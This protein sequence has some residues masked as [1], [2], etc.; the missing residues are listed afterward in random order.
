MGCTPSMHTSKTGVIYCQDSEESPSSYTVKDSNHQFA[1]LAGH[2]RTDVTSDPAPYA[3]TPMPMLMPMPP[4]R[5]ESATGLKLDPK[6]VP[7]QRNFI[8]VEKVEVTFLSINLSGLIKT[9]V[10]TVRHRSGLFNVVHN[11]LLVMLRSSGLRLVTFYPFFDVHALENNNVKIGSF[12]MTYESLKVLFVFPKEDAQSEAFWWAA[13]KMQYKTDMVSNHESALACYQER[14]H[15]IVIVDGRNSKPIEAEVF[16]RQDFYSIFFYFYRCVLSLRAVNGSSNTVSAIIVKRSACLDEDLTV[17]PFLNAVQVGHLSTGRENGAVLFDRCRKL[18]PNFSFQWFVECPSRGVCLSELIQLETNDFR[19][20]LRLQATQTMLAAL[21]HCRDVIEVTSAKGEMQVDYA[22]TLVH[23]ALFCSISNICYFVAQYINKTGEQLFGYNCSEISGKN[24]HDIHKIDNVRTQFNDAIEVQLK[25]GKEWEGLYMSRRKSGDAISTQAKI[26]PVTTRSNKVTHHVYIKDCS[27][28]TAF[29]DLPNGKENINIDV[30]KGGVKPT[31]KTSY[32]IKSLTEGIDY[33]KPF[34]FRCIMTTL[35]NRRQSMARIAAM[36]IEA[37]ITKVINFIAAAQENCPVYVAQ[38]LDKALDILRSTELYSPQWLSQQ[39]KSD[40]PITID[41]LGGLLSQGPKIPLNVRRQSEVSF[42]KSQSLQ[43][44]LSL[45]SL[46]I[47]PSNIKSLLENESKWSFNVL[48]LEAITNKRPLVWLGM[49]IF[50]R[51]RVASVLNTDETT[52]QNWLTLI[53]ANYHAQNPY[54]NSTHAA[55]VLQAAACFLDR[56]HIK[57]IFDPLDEAA[58]LLAAAIHDTDHPGKNSAFLCNSNNELA[59]LYNDLSVL[60]SHHS[61]LAFKLTHTDKRVNIFANMDKDDY[62]TIRHSI[63]D[64]V[65]AT[66]MTKHFEHL[67]KFVNSFTKPINEESEFNFEIGQETAD[68][69]T[70]VK[71]VLIK[72]ADVSNPARGLE[73]CIE[74]AHR[75]ATEYFQQTEEEK[76]K[77]LPIVMPMFDRTTCSIPKSQIGFM[78]YFVNDMFESWDV[79][80]DLPELMENLHKNYQYW[81]EQ[82]TRQS[83]TENEPALEPTSI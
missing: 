36:S 2:Y 68:N 63:I 8:S 27:S 9:L 77:G 74:W 73:L 80:A 64:M 19:N 35:M 3:E 52:L 61:A 62:R 5:S 11:E 83:L 56:D 17:I 21:A 39:T 55:D 75:I 10:L 58:C 24:I 46:S 12:A 26:L 51:F 60:E 38:T 50:G 33:Q 71:R 59:I 42:S 43:P 25:N 69:I 82:E 76:A 30:L 4:S 37:P 81:K 78:D 67:A 44:S 79:F 57:Q 14:Y 45:P 7:P 41:L 22:T 53:E 13:K 49:A 47:I 18:G 15:D 31:R 66:E 23:F 40:D 72:C 6:W 34:C 29:G 20:N 1:G 48:Q 65:L 32:D 16:C 70:L 54:H 28:R